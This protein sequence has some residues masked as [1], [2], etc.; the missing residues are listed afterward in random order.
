M[1]TLAESK[2][3]RPQASKMRFSIRSITLAPTVR[4]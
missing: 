3:R 2:K 4:E 1:N